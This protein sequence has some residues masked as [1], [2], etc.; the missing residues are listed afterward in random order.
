[1]FQMIFLEKVSKI[2]LGRLLFIFP[3]RK[4][5]LFSVSPP[6]NGRG[7]ALWKV[8]GG[9]IARG[10]SFERSEKGGGAEDGDVFTVRKF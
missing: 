8:G 5:K 3:A 6:G 10:K 7:V 1:M 4:N 2:F 9:A